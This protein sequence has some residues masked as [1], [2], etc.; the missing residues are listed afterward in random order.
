[1]GPHRANPG[2]VYCPNSLVHLV[3]YEVA[4][5]SSLAGLCWGAASPAL[6]RDDVLK[7]C[8]CEH[9]G[10]GVALC[11]STACTVCQKQCVETLLYWKQVSFL[12]CSPKRR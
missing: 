12:G 10:L 7:I 5:P 8:S 2:G 6:H 1:M 4:E 11:P 3:V 9:L